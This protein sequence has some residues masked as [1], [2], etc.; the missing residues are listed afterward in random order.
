MTVK[1]RI[2]AALRAYADGESIVEV[3]HAQT[4]GDAVDGLIAKHAGLR[5]H[6]LDEAGA[7]RSFVNVYLN[8]T[9]VRTL[10]QSATPVRAGDTVLILPS[11]AGG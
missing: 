6:L 2:P 7:L 11:V 8:Q 4:V 5:A 1:V 10:R 3:A 9:D